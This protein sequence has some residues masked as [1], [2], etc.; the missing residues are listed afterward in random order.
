MDEEQQE[1][2]FEMHLQQNNINPNN[3]K[4]TIKDSHIKES[5]NKRANDQDDNASLLGDDTSMNT[6]DRDDQQS[7][8]GESKSYIVQVSTKLLEERSEDREEMIFEAFAASCSKFI[9]HWMRNGLITGLLHTEIS[10]VFDTITE[11]DSWINDFRIVGKSH[12]YAQMYFQVHSIAP[13]KELIDCGKAIFRQENLSVMLKRTKTRGWNRKVGLLLGPKVDKASLKDYE[14]ELQESY[15]ISLDDFELR[16]KTE[17]EGVTEALCIV[18]YAVESKA[19]LIDSKLREM[20][21]NNFDTLRYYSYINGSAEERTSALALNRLIG[22][23]M[24]YEI[25]KGVKV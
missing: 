10:K 7:W 15:D 24:K 22:M 13:W 18:I 2:N 21:F 19:E 1:S 11:Y 17:K 12:V 6:Q 3:N 4:N 9:R 16:K 5:K 20:A 8:K 25:L 14:E 23:R